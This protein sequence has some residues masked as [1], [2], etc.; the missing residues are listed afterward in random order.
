MKIWRAHIARY[1]KAVFPGEGWVRIRFLVLLVI[2][3]VLRFWDLPNIPY[4]HDEISALVR[5][6][7]SLY[8]TIKIG[9]I[10][11]DTHPPG[12]Q[13]FEW[14]WTRIF[15]KGEAMVKLPFIL[16]SL[17]AIFFLY[18][19]A[20]LW[21]G[22]AV[23][24]A[25]T[26]LMATLQYSVMYGQIARPYAVGLFTT[27]LLADQLTRYLAFSRFRNL[28]G[29]LIAA[30]LSA[31][32]HHFSLM[33]AGLMVL[34]G[35]FLIQRDQR[36]NYL[37]MCGIGILLYLPNV[38]IF[39]KQLSIGGLSEWLSPPDKHWLGDY[40]MYIAHWSVPFAIG[41]IGL[42]LLSI[43]LGLWKKIPSTPAL[44]IFLTWGLV[45]LIIGLLYSIYRA[46]VIQYSMVLFSFPYVVIALLI[47]FSRLERTTTIVLV[48]VITAASM[49]TLIGTR[50]H[51]TIFYHSKYEEIV[52]QGVSAYREHGI[53]GAE[54]LIDAPDEVIRFY[55]DQWKIKQHEFPYVQLRETMSPGH[56]E[57]RLRSL[58]GRQ[59]V[60]GQTN[61]APAEQLARIQFH[62][63]NMIMRKDMAEGQVFL[64]NN[65]KSSSI[66]DRELIAFATP[67]EKA[68]HWEIDPHMALI[69]DG[70]SIPAWDFT[71]REFGL[72][73]SLMPDTLI[74]H[75]QDQFEIIAYL[76]VQPP[77]R[78]AAVAA[79]FFSGDSSV[80]Y[81]DGQLNDM[82]T[83]EGREHLIVALR[84]HDPQLRGQPLK[85]KT[86]IYNMGLGP[87][88]V[89]R[90]EVWLRKANRYQYAILGPLR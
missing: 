78:E 12:V 90:M 82:L 6:F 85:L 63:P 72:A 48:A 3:A 84:P 44:W 29:I 70:D 55:M 75:V 53:E 68:G 40:G 87:I 46:P 28:R 39:L 77:A 11:L 9:V 41:L 19:V 8:D 60:Y 16:M 33:L 67:R 2:A 22:S 79:Q 76:R 89:E 18:R 73:L 64:F 59:I 62:F 83:V 31:Y 17:A 81:R 42:V 43:S 23:A 30:V 7:P 56:L 74:G 80:F 36:R 49:V 51:Y 27:A 50:E 66:E 14:I 69:E 32:T 71:G 24:L 86:Y 15:G 13:V 35:F 45:P 21:T 58:Y 26:A 10:E 34:T 4:T 38:P 1:G 54:V 88:G 5:I 25:L 65:E 57:Q 47:G 61:G 52:R 37:F 20:L